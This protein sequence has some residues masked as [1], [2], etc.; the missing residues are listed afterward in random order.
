[1][2]L[3][4]ITNLKIQILNYVNLAILTVSLAKMELLIISVKLVTEHKFYC[5]INLV[6]INVEPNSI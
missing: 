5:L 1:M 6:R 3:V 2:I 4:K